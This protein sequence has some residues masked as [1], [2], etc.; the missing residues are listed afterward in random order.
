MLSTREVQESIP[1]ISILFLGSMYLILLP[2]S[3]LLVSDL[4]IIIFLKCGCVFCASS[5]DLEDVAGC[6]MGA[7][8]SE[9][10]DTVGG[11]DELM[12][13]IVI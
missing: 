11:S 4:V 5:S 10:V 8:D 12:D 9:F 7:Y 1:H 13:F 2:F 6:E 3:L